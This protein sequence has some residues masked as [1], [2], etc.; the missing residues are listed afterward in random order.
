M[1]YLE[2]NEHSCWNLFGIF[3]FIVSKTNSIS[4]AET[5]VEILKERLDCKTIDPNSLEFA[6]NKARQ[7]SQQLEITP[8]IV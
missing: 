1:E 2:S 8:E 3:Q 6:Q 7:F 5:I 4:D